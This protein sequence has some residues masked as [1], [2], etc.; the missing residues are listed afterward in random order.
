VASGA[1]GAFFGV[2]VVGQTACNQSATL[3]AVSDG[4]VKHH[5][6]TLM[7]GGRLNGTVSLTSPPTKS[8]QGVVPRGPGGFSFK[9]SEVLDQKQ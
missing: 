8:P 6:E 4:A 2:A 7:E 9:S 3:A 5:E 1:N